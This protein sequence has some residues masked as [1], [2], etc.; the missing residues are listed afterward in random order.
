MSTRPFTTIASRI[1]VY[2]IIGVG[3]RRSLTIFEPIASL[4]NCTFA[5]H[6]PANRGERHRMLWIRLHKAFRIFEFV[7]TAFIV[8]SHGRAR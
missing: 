3:G 7:R 1:S 6:R 4:G 2:F 8:V 5:D